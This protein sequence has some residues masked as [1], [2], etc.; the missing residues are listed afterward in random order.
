MEVTRISGLYRLPVN[1]R[2]DVLQ[3]HGWLDEQAAMALREG[4][5]ILSPAAADKVIENVIGVFA[6]PFAVAPN[7]IVNEQ[8]Y[9]VPL[10]VEEPSIVAGLSAAA[11]MAQ[12]TGGFHAHCDESLLIGQI[13]VGDIRN[14]KL[15]IQDLD[16]EKD[17]L[18]QK[19]EEVHPRLRERGGGVRDIEFRQHRLGSGSW[20]V[21]VDILVDTC[22][23]M[24]ANLVNTLCEALAPDVEAICGGRVAMRILSNLADR[25]IV[26][27]SVT[28]PLALLRAPGHSTEELRDAIVRANEIAMA[29]PYRAA[30]HNKGI[31]NGIDPLAIATGNDW[32]AIEAGAHAYAARNGSYQPLTRWS[33]SE[34]GDLHGEI[35]IPLKVGTVGGTLASNPAAELGLA[36]TG[37][38][39]AVELAK[40]MAAVGLAQNF[41]AIRAL[42]SSGIQHGHMRLHA[43]SL[44]AAAGTPAHLFDE[45]TTRLIASGEIKDWKAREILDA[46][47][48]DE[49]FESPTTGR[50]AGKVI[51]L[52]EHAVVYGKHAVAVPVRDSVAA[53][54]TPAKDRT[55]IE[56][57]D[58]QARVELAADPEA[59]EGPAAA[60]RCVMRELDV[61]DRHFD[62]RIRSSLPRA[63]GLGSSAAVAVAVVRAFAHALDIELDN[64]AVNRI[65]FECEKIAHGTPSGVDNTVSTYG[66]PMLFQRHKGLHI[67]EL[68]PAEPLPLVVAFSHQR[69]LTHKVVDGVKKRAAVGGSRYASIFDEIDAI[70]LAGAEALE[71]GRLSE[72]GQLMNVCQGLLNAIEVSTPELER[73]VSIARRAGAIGAKL[74]GAG[75]GGSIISLCPDRQGEVAAALRHGGFECIELTLGSAQD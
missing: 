35:E 67:R 38:G 30:T 63:M 56:V 10:V 27:A 34:S 20:L 40:L 59:D 47:K 45:A 60:I 68:T 25:S 54:V 44:V 74:T 52:G 22:D 12:R 9:I 70:S 18:M 66:R 26:T 65:A 37:V 15:A 42:S 50:A 46:L 41:A 73:M 69:G 21:T 33:V 72:L 71:Q 29:D 6:L 11:R 61:A 13:H 51:L 62:V 64:E 32:R 24:G 16:A 49:D 17:A 8:D 23:A 1:E 2:I 36:M 55:T 57:P 31:M 14:P 5:H 39:S 53:R 7:F 19:A 75:G 58:W 3:E 28:Y 4:R 43:R 48:A